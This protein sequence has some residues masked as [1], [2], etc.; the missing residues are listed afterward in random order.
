MASGGLRR[1]T[2]ILIAS[3]GLGG[4]TPPPAAAPDSA[5]LAQLDGFALGMTEAD[6]FAGVVLV[7]RNGQILFER[8]YG[9]RD[10]AGDAPTTID[11]RYDLASAGKMFTSVAVLQQIAAGRLT[12]DTQGWRDPAGISQ[13]RLRR[14]GHRPP[15]PHPQR[16]RR[17]H[18]T[19]RHRECGQS[20]A[21]PQ[22]CRYGRAARRSR[23]R[24]PSGVEA[25]IWQFR[26]SWCSGVWSRWFP[27]SRTKPICSATS[28]PPPG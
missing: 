15:A 25:G 6:Q 20:R 12:L 19:V 8:A 21:G 7:A 10:M 13:P 4:A 11:T 28:S 16:G 24:I 22:R 9:M 5:A 18:R 17:R 14:Y 1:V 2:A 3:L 23:A 26:A 27:A